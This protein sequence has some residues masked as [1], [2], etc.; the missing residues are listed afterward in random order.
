MCVLAY[1]PPHTSAPWVRM[2]MLA[3]GLCVRACVRARVRARV[4]VLPL[5]LW[6]EVTSAQLAKVLVALH[7]DRACAQQSRN[8]MGRVR[9]CRHAGGWMQNA[10]MHLS[11]EAGQQRHPCRGVMMF[12]SGAIAVS[13]MQFKCGPCTH[14]EP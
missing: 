11:A 14:A 6:E 7:V 10:C 9:A 13:S 4:R 5:H 1:K 12:S 8:S 2:C 3:R